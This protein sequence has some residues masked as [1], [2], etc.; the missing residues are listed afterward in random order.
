MAAGVSTFAVEE[1]T[2]WPAARADDDDDEAAWISVALCLAASGGVGAWL[3]APADELKLEPSSLSGCLTLFRMIVARLAALDVGVAAGAVAGSLAVAADGLL[4]A[5]ALKIG[6]PT[7]SLGGS[8]LS[9][10]LICGEVAPGYVCCF[11][12]TARTDLIMAVREAPPPLA[13]PAA[14]GVSWTA[15]IPGGRCALVSC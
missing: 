15:R 8:N 6:E 3:A 11:L 14:D 9:W 7:L 1:L 4:A 13:A 5:A 2:D 12:K 10:P